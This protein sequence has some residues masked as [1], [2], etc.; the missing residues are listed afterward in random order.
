MWHENFDLYFFSLIKYIWAPDEHPKT[1]LQN[2]SNSQRYSLTKFNFSHSPVCK[3]PGSEIFLLKNS[4]FKTFK[5]FIHNP[6]VH[7][8]KDLF[9][10]FLLKAPEVFKIFISH[11]AGCKTLPGVLHTEECHSPVS[12]TPPSFTPQCA[13]HQG[14]ST[15]VSLSSLP[16]VL[17]TA[18]FYSTGS[19]TPLSLTPRCPTHHQVSLPSVQD[20]GDVC[21]S[22]SLLAPWCPAIRGVCSLNF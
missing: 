2:F 12:C 22:F 17:N 7:I 6:S 15:K 14:M 19:C 4:I 8:W 5:H 9:T 1:V 16:G 13:G 18:E 11:S 20:T 3:T 10:L 21:D